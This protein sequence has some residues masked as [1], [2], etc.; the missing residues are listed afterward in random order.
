MKTCGKCK[1]IK[2]LDCFGNDKSKI[3]GK[4]IYCKICIN[5]KNR[6]RF[7]NNPKKIK[8]CQKKDQHSL[9]Y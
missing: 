2:T 6:L 8:K 4:L 3:D 5:Y 9:P 1:E 7:K